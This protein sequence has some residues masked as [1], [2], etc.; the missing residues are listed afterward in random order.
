MKLLTILGALI[1][2][3]VG[4]GVGMARA[5]EWSGIFWRATLSAVAAGLLLRWWG[6][7]WL[8]C[9]DT[10]NKERAAEA[11]K[12]AAPAPAPETRP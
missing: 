4:V 9:W 1:G 11:A 6:H 12:A 10:A 2:F 7:L 5:N 8:Q 3:S